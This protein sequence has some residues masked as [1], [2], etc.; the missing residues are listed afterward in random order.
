MAFGKFQAKV[1]D[2]GSMA[3]LKQLCFRKLPSSKTR[4]ESRVSFAQAAETSKELYFF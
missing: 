2:Q 3:A 4:Q 1:M